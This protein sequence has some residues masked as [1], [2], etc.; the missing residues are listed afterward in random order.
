LL[1]S[2]NSADADAHSQ[3]PEREN[4]L[5]HGIKSLPPARFELATYGL[6]NRTP[7]DPTLN[8]SEPCDKQQTS[9]AQPLAQTI[10]TPNFDSDLTLL[11]E[12]WDSLPQPVRAGIVAMVKASAPPD[13]G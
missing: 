7:V 1:E 11:I 8:S 4:P 13:K 2:S 9:L 6:G 12:C 5:K 3:L 10:Q